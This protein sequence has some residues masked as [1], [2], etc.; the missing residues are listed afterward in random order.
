[1]CSKFCYSLTGA[2]PIYAR[3]QGVKNQNLIMSITKDDVFSFRILK[4]LFV[5]YAFI[6]FVIDLCMKYGSLRGTY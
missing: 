1:M 4:I 2:Q 6:S 3:I 5:E